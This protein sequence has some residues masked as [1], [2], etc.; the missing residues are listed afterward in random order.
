MLA[1]A[2]E[3]WFQEDPLLDFARHAAQAYPAVCGRLSTLTGVD[4]HYRQEGT[5]VA[6][7]TRADRETLHRLQQAQVRHGLSVERLNTRQARRLT[8]ALAPRSDDDALSGA[9]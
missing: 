8:P 2:S 9:D 6:A 1:P 5:L 7:A 4:L 3:Y